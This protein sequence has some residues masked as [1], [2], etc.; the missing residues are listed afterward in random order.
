MQDVGGVKEHI[1]GSRRRRPPGRAGRASSAR[2]P[3]GRGR[4][5]RGLARHGVARPEPPRPRTPRHPGTGRGRDPRARLRAGRG[6]PAPARRLLDDHRADAARRLEPRLHGDR[7]RGGG[8]HRR[9]AV[10]GPDV[11]QRPRHGPRAALPARVRRAA[12]RRA[13]GDPQRPGPRGGPPAAARRHPDG[14]HRPRRRRARPGSRSRSTTGPAGRC[15]PTTCTGSAT[16]AIAYVGN[17]EAA[18]PVRARFAAL[19]RPA[20]ARRAGPSSSSSPPR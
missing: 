4:P 5:R 16:G 9:R 12:R 11:E 13:A 15:R 1:P 14:G 20:R 3:G 17:P 18:L 7:P 2:E 10:D 6:G 19:Q 8:P